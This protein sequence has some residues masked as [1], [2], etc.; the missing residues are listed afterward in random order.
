MQIHTHLL[1]IFLKNNNYKNNHNFSN[2][3]NN[4][5]PNSLVVENLSHTYTKIAKI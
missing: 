3:Y 5:I 1:N 4:Q 2:N